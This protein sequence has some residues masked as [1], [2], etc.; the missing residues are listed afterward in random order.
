M[1][2]CDANERESREL[3]RWPT[4]LGP[5]LPQELKRRSQLPAPDPSC[6][7]MNAALGDLKILGARHNMKLR[8]A[9]ASTSAPTLQMT[10]LGGQGRVY[11]LV[12]GRLVNTTEPNQSFAHTFTEEGAYTITA[13]DLT[14]N[15]DSISLHVVQ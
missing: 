9:G 5:W 8:Q 10:P 4:I 12:N 11:W 14:G 3:A 2:N 13:T 7:P 15:Y 1:A 6:P